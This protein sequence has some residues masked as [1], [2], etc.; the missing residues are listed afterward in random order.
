[1]IASIS[2]KFKLL[3]ILSVCVGLGLVVGRLGTDIWSSTKDA[4]FSGSQ[5]YFSSNELLLEKYQEAKVTALDWQSLLPSNELDVITKYQGIKSQDSADMSSQILR[6][7]EAATDPEYKAALQS[8]NVVGAYQDQIVAISGFIVPIDYYPDK[9]VKNMFLVPYF[10]ACLHFPPPPPN[11]IIFATL[12]AGFKSLELN[13]AYTLTG[14]IK[15]GLFEDPMGTSAYRLDVISI[16]A[17]NGQPD[18]VRRH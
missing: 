6:S 8:T 12:E 16:A 11:Q 14:E 7:I 15:L 10:G 18:D 17:F 3:L 4:L 9:T 5:E 2:A 1:M 13:Q